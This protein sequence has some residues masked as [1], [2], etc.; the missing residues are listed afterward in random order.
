MSDRTVSKLY[1]AKNYAF[2]MARNRAQPS[3]KNPAMRFARMKERYELEGV[4]RSVYGVLL[5]NL[6]SH[7]H[8]LLQV[9][10][11]DAKL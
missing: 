9:S 11:S 3:S 7:P 4:R 2:V 5:V 10:Q 8:V 1:P 6:N